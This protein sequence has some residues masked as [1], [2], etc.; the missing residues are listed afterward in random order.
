MAII[1][2]HEHSKSSSLEPKGNPS[3]EAAAKQPAVSC[4]Y[5]VLRMS[6]TQTNPDKTVKKL[7]LQ[8]QEVASAGEKQIQEKKL[9]IS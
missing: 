3:T 7:L 1:K 9:R 4:F 6:T 8:A 5:P 2:I